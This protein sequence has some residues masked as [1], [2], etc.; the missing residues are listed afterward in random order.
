MYLVSGGLKISK[1]EFF[2][3]SD[4]FW[5]PFFGFSLL[6]LVDFLTATREHSFLIK[7]VHVLKGVGLKLKNRVGFSVLIQPPD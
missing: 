3:S 6:L 2:V 7:F 1:N 4:E 5:F